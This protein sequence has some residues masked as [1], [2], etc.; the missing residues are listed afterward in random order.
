MNKLR[1]NCVYLSGGIDRVDLETA[2]NW[3]V[4][5]AR[6]L[7]TWDILVIDPLEKPI[8]NVESFEDKDFR[9]K[10]SKLRQESKYH[11]LRELMKPVR[12]SD[13]RA[14]DK[15]DFA[16]VYLDMT[17]Q[18]FGTID[19]ISYLDS[20][21]KP[22]LIMAAEGVQNLPYWSYCM[23][24]T[25]MLFNNWD[26]LKQYIIDVAEGRKS[27]RRFVFWDWDKLVDG[28]RLEYSL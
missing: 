27:N 25:E 18:L 28:T 12:A 1:G 24:E 23:T 19:E 26:D 8:I 7:K 17:H 14:C 20:Q 6:F 13:L 2:T 11:E 10:R 22:I 9:E 15:S 16:I 5:I 3:R 4:D 21:R